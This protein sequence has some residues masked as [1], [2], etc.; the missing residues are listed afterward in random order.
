MLTM[1]FGEN[2]V[3]KS[4]AEIRWRRLRARITRRFRSLNIHLAFCG[5]WQRQARG[6][7]HFH[8]IVNHPIDVNWLRPVAEACGFGRQIRLDYIKPRN[9]YRHL[10]KSAA[11]NYIARYVSR[12]IGDEDENVRVTFAYDSLPLCKDE[13][14]RYIRPNRTKVR[15]WTF[16]GGLARLHR[17]GCVAMWGADNY[18]PTQKESGM[19]MSGDGRPALWHAAE[20][21]WMNPYEQWRAL[22]WEGWRRLPPVQQDSFFASSEGVK[23]F[24]A[25]EGLVECP[26]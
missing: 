10:G 24:L 26:F 23:W 9:G 5:A 20:R 18:P 8:A 7:W 17:L 4:E 25:G 19:R 6:A 11:V 2:L 22:V 16:V 3:D 14:G 1:T 15:G 21:R 12:D 13:H